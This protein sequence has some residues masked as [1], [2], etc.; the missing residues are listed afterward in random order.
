MTQVTDNWNFFMGHDPNALVQQFGSPLYVYNEHIFRKRCHEMKALATYHKFRVNYAMK[1]NSNLSLLKIA[2]EEGLCIDASSQGEVLMAL[3]AGFLPEE[4][5][6]IA[7][8]ISPEE[9][10]FAVDNHVLLSVD[11]LSQLNTFGSMFPGARIA[12]RFNTGIGAGHHAKVVTGGDDTKFGITLDLINDVKKLL[13]MHQLKLVGINH[14]IGSQYVEAHY[15]E[16]IRAL[17]DL[18]LSFEQLEFVDFGGGF[19]IPYHKQEGERHQSLVN[20]GLAI[21]AQMSHFN[22][23]YGRELICMIEPGRYIAAE[24]GVLLGTVH[25]VKNV[26]PNKYAGTDMGFSVFARMALYDAHHDVEVY[27]KDARATEII[28]VVGDQCESGDYIA[29]K[30]RLPMLKN[31]D[32]LGVLDVGAYGYSMSSQYNLRPRPAEVL[33]TSSGALKL[34]RRA[35]TY[36]SMLENMQGL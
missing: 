12:L 28:N 36:T 8:N 32:V 6:F 7:N 22:V 26:G 30:R 10:R 4:I 35:D 23:K 1:A 25:A 18:A 15:L 33:I 5:L 2:R 9:M 13:A 29:A 16:G 14:H 31:D 27:V 34:I 3:A 19:Y 24:C 17:L 11:S 21:D 20:V